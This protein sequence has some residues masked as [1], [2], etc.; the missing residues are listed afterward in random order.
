[1]GREELDA[2]LGGALGTD[3]EDELGADVKDEWDGETPDAG[4]LL[5][6]FETA[7][8]FGSDAEDEGCIFLGI[9]GSL[10]I[11]EEVGGGG[12]RGRG[13]RGRGL[14]LLLVVLVDCFAGG[15]LETCV[16]LE[17][18]VMGTFFSMGIRGRAEIGFI[19]KDV[20][21]GGGFLTGGAGGGAATG[22]AAATG[23]GGAAT[24]AGT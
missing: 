12:G 7:A 11:A 23:A 5:T 6:L 2:G 10:L 9:F 24:G 18:G 3:E 16:L 17:T 14:L 22:G 20:G 1:M 13:L 15:L 19:T 4:F 8:F 21:E